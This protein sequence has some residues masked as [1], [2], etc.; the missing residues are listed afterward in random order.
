MPARARSRSV[1]TPPSVLVPARV[2]QVGALRFQTACCCCRIAA[3][4]SDSTATLPSLPLAGF[5]ALM[6]AEGT[7]GTRTARAGSDLGVDLDHVMLGIGEKEGPVTP[8]LIR[9]RIEDRHPVLDQFRL[10]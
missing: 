5:P 8:D 7:I 4:A 6:L 3:F 2:R 1:M 9:H 10:A